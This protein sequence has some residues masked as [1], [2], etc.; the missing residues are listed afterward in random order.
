MKKSNIVNNPLDV[1]ITAGGTP[2]EGE[3][4]F[5]NCGGKPK[6][7]L[8][9]AGKPMIQWVLDA[10]S[11]SHYVKRVVII[12]LPP[13]TDLY[14]DHPLTIQET[15]G[16]ILTNLQAG[17]LALQNMGDIS[18]KVLVVSSDIPAITGEMV[19]W[20]INTVH[21]SDHD[22]YYNVIERVTMEKK[23]PSSKRT[24]LKL[25][26][27]EV[28]GGD[29]N[30]IDPL[31][32]FKKQSLFDQIIGSRK[33]P[34]KQASILGFDTLFLILLKKM[35]L[36]RAE[37]NISKKIGARG[38]AIICPYAEVGM[39]VDKPYQLAELLSS[40]QSTGRQN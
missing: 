7:L 29:V 4:L 25:A 28:C 3:P 23:Y 21:Q 5:E 17:V 12:G 15:H 27:V 2:R 22:L 24:Y 35:T 1:I 38:H 32:V 10:L 33:N 18:P 37:E 6:A 8:D 9:F 34:L 19:D 26:D 36:H 31:F 40:F 39:D 11:S 16:S 13:F 20:I 14:C 30:A